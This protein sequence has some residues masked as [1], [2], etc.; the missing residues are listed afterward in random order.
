MKRVLNLVAVAVLIFVGVSVSN[1]S[2][3]IKQTDLFTIVAN[4]DVAINNMPFQKSWTIAYGDAGKNVVV[5][6]RTTKKGEEYLVRNEFFEVRY[7]NTEKGFGVRLVRNADSKVD[8]TINSLVLNE[9]MLA[10][11][12]IIWSEML[13]E[14][15]ALEYIADFVPTLL[16]ENYKHLLN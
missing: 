14:Q 16:N 6:K 8:F 12:T 3:T 5:L 13:T 9:A 4:D 11:Q 7:L 15:K 10:Q 1:A 2:N